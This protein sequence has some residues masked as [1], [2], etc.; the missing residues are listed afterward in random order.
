MKQ[1]IFGA[2]L[3]GALVLS[4]AATA[5]ERTVTLAV[6]NMTCVSCPYIVK[7][8]MESVSG[9][10]NVTVSYEVKTATVTFDDAETTIEAIAQASANSGFPAKPLR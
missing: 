8:S 4:T 9:V 5:A 2:T 7:K 3:S 1:L 6:E 10:S